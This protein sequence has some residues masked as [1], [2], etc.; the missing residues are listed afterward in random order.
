ML[1]QVAP[2]L[3]D[4]VAGHSSDSKSQ[5]KDSVEN[6]PVA[7]DY[8]LPP[9]GTRKRV[10]P[11]FDRQ[12]YGGADSHRSLRSHLPTCRHRAVVFLPPPES[13]NYLLGNDIS[14]KSNQHAIG[15]LRA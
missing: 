7:A 14:L 2:I 8:D 11:A 4:D 12:A 3:I 5:T 9:S 13:A 10:R 6:A 1:T 15:I